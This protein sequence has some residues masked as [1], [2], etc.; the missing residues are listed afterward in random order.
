MN[1]KQST[2]PPALIAV[3]TCVAHMVVGKV[4]HDSARPHSTP[5]ELSGIIS[6]SRQK[7]EI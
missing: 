3:I 6:S 7:D 1:I 2:N 5:I 4:L